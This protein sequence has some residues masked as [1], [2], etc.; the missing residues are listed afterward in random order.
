MIRRML[1]HDLL[2]PP[3][4]KGQRIYGHITVVRQSVLAFGG[5]VG[6]GM[7]ASYTSRLRLQAPLAAENRLTVGSSGNM[8][9][10]A[11]IGLS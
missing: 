10:L 8:N 6:S 4:L 11:A 3:T 9:E 2:L 1:A 5:T 7:M